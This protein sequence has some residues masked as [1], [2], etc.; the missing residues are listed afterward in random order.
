MKM[1]A[2]G[3]QAPAS[4][5]RMIEA[6]GERALVDTFLSKRPSV[7]ERMTAGRA[8]RNQLPRSAQAKYSKPGD[9]SDPVE[10]LLQH[11]ATRIQ[12]LLP[13]RYGRMLANPFGFFRGAAGLMASDLSRLPISD[14]PVVACGDAHVKN[15]GVYASAERNLVF[16]IN[17]YDEVHVAPWEWDLKRL[18]T[19][20]A[21][22]AQFLGGDKEDCED[23]ARE[24]VRTY[25]ERISLRRNG[26]PRSLV[27]PHRRT[28]RA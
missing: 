22:A 23:A 8:L 26:L 14:T 15:F 28:R 9:R 27:R 13:L 1:K 5:Y 4:F 24:C 20:A 25:R 18:A 10:M 7:A 11:D 21:L 16:A 12:E 6:H 2:S 17:D 19:S 3:L